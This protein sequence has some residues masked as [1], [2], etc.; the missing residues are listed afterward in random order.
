[1]VE[2]QQFLRGRR[3]FG[4]WQQQQQHATRKS[5][6]TTTAVLQGDSNY[7]NNNSIRKFAI[8][9]TTASTNHAV[10]VDSSS[11]DIGTKLKRPLQIDILYA[12]QTGTA[13]LFATQLAEAID[14]TA[15]S[16]AAADNNDNDDG[17]AATT[18][19]TTAPLNQATMLVDI[20]T[21]YNNNDNVNSNDLVHPNT[22]WY[23]FVVSTSG[24][25]EPPDNSRDF[26]N[27][28]LALQQQQGQA[29]EAAMRPFAGI[30]Y[31]IFAL[32]NSKAH[33]AHYCAFGNDLQRLMQWA[34]AVEVLPMTLGDDGG[35]DCAIEDD[36]DQWQDMVLQ[37]L[38]QCGSSRT[39]LPND[40]AAARTAAATATADVTAAAAAPP[41]STTVSTN[42]TTFIAPT[43]KKS[44]R[45][46]KYPELQLQSNADAGQQ[47]LSSATASS[48]LLETA[49]DFYS[50]GAQR[51]RV[52]KNTVLRSDS[53]NAATNPSALRE[54]QLSVLQSPPATTTTTTMADRDTNHSYVTGDHFIVYPRN[55]DILVEA[56]LNVVKDCPDPHAVILGPVPAITLSTSNGSHDKHDPAAAKSA[57]YPHPTGIT[58]YETLRHCVDL[59]A[60]PS[61]SLARW[62]TGK[63][64]DEMDYKREILV[65]RRTVLDFLCEEDAGDEKGISL[66]DLLYQLPPLQHR[67]YSIA[68]SSLVHPD[69]IYLTY[70]PVKYVTARGSLRE[71]N[72]TGYL[73][74]IPNNDSQQA[75]QTVTAAIRSNPL[76]RLPVTVPGATPPPI[77]MIAGGCGVAPIRAFLEELCW[78]ARQPKDQASSL[79]GPVHLFLG[80]RHPDDAVYSDLVNEAAALGLLAGQHITYTSGCVQCSLVSDAVLAQAAAVYNLLTRDRAVVYICGGA[81]TFGVAIQNAIDEILQTEGGMSQSEATAFL[82]ELIESRRFHEDLSD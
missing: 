25:G 78:N 76:F 16:M 38:E 5:T 2:P 10:A 48:D 46:T 40:E 55:S 60:L 75:Q 57:V 11:V 22:T 37:R 4:W 27:Q 54:L 32:G 35:A 79:Y 28:L 41:S 77:V 9:S 74:N 44:R 18:A 82:Q 72:C 24:V 45:P 23:M 39:A 1:M 70:R 6:R 17:T 59:Q 81:R 15:T 52:L 62:L 64:R 7:W 51:W 19:T 67:Y 13:Q 47:L 43:A 69:T 26:Y 3:P 63:G 34:G 20:M 61:P 65:P 36:F 68:S 29:T 58:I 21:R 80:F 73:S 33:S 42:V 71:G 50:R 49:P 66:H 14:E 30:P 8:A 56:Y 53:P 31:C 12:S